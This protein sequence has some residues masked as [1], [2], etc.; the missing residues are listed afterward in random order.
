MLLHCAL[1]ITLMS[2]WTWNRAAQTLPLSQMSPSPF[3]QAHPSKTQALS[4]DI[5]ES[6]GWG[7]GSEQM[8]PRMWGYGFSHLCS[9][10]FEG[11]RKYR[12]EKITAPH[13]H[14][15]PELFHHHDNQMPM[16]PEYFLKGKQCL[17]SLMMCLW[18]WM[19]KHFSTVSVYLYKQWHNQVESSSQNW[20]LYKWQG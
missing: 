8:V 11:L 9:L 16:G 12:E 20:P 10:L 14:V 13:Y 5:Q 15:F 6:L 4:F 3:P 7:A 2:L 17:W 18:I 19:K 1:Y